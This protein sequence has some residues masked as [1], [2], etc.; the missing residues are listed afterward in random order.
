MT[1]VQAHATL[2]WPKCWTICGVYCPIGDE[3]RDFFCRFHDLFHAIHAFIVTFRGVTVK[4][5]A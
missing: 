1:T 4:F 3:G 5:L 2:S